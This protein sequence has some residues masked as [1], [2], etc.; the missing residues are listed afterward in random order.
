MFRRA[1]EGRRRVLGEQHA[2]TLWSLLGVA[3]LLARQEQ[4]EEAAAVYEQVIDGRRRTLGPDHADTLQA[5][6]E[7][8]WLLKDR[9]ETRARAE[10]VAREAVDGCRRSLGEQHQQTVW[11]TDTLAVIL[12]MRGRN[13]DAIA[14]FEPALRVAKQ[15]AGEN[16]WSTMLSTQHFGRALTELGR[17]GEAEALLLDALDDVGENGGPHYERAESLREALVELYVRSGEPKKAEAY[18]GPQSRP[19]HAPPDE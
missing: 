11:T 15:I 16:S 19:V 17:Y 9:A 2:S 12:H 10:S 14:V 5:M 18:R 8:A 4:A 13:E 1:H 6:N 3:Q 7:L